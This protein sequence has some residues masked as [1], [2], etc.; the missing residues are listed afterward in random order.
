LI[1]KY[2]ES[3]LL[4]TTKKSELGSESMAN[5]LK[6]LVDMNTAMKHFILF[7]GKP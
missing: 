2:Q 7:L 5:I 3:G 4:E 6:E 1:K